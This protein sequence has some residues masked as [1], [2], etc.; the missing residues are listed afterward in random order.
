MNAT[1]RTACALALAFAASAALAQQPVQIVETSPTEDAV[2]V[3]LETEVQFLLNK[4]TPRQGSAFADKFFWSPEDST[5]LG[6]FG[7]DCPARTGCNTEPLTLIFYTLTHTDDTDFTFVA[8]GVQAADGA[9]MARPFT[10]NYS[11]APTRGQRAV[12]GRV[13]VAD[14]PPA[15]AGAG[16]AQAGAVLSRMVSRA[17]PSQEPEV[18]R[19]AAR[20]QPAP[21]E[22]SVRMVHATAAPAASMERA[23]VLLLSDFS[24]NADFWAARSSTVPALDG[25]YTLDGVRPGTYYPA[26]FSYAD[27]E[28]ERIGAYGYYDPDGDFDPDPITVATGADLSDV[29]LALYAYAPATALDRRAVAERLADGAADGQRLVEVRSLVGRDASGAV[30]ADGTAYEWLYTFYSPSEDRLTYVSVG[31]VEASLSTGAAS[32]GEADQAAIGDGGVDSDRALETADT[33]A[34]DAFRARYDQPDD[35]AAT[36]AAGDLD[37]AVRPFGSRAFWAVTYTSPEG[38]PYDEETVFIDAATGAVLEGRPVVGEPSPVAARA[39]LLPPAP[40]PTTGPVTVRFSLVEGGRARLDLFDLQGRQL[41]TLADGPFG[42]GT[43]AVAWDGALPAGTYVV[44]LSTG[45]ETAS[46]LVVRAR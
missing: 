1:L 7:H 16:H 24:T 43:H 23:V 11:T 32:G 15:S 33:E 5:T 25:A 18:R 34:G 26:V 20:R 28:G 19:V 12:S 30:F 4:P 46:R 6:A 10:L 36:L 42:P 44:R 14:G 38:E 45:A 3:P 9:R 41:A 29:A 21:G 8:Y 2:N 35:V 37:L 27:E 40:N 22:A 39:A 13:S 17:A 31:P